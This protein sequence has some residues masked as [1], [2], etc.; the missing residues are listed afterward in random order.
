MEIL[1]KL[2]GKIDGKEILKIQF[3]NNNNYSVEF[4]N[5]GGYFHSICIPYQND[6][7]KTE[8]VL[9]GYHDFKSYQSD[10]ACLNALIGRVGGRIRN[11]E[12]FLNN[13]KFHLDLN[14]NSH[15][16]HGGKDGFNSQVW[17]ISDLIEEEQEM[18]C[19]LTYFSK[20]LEGGYPGNLNCETIYSLNNTNELTMEFFAQRDQDTIVNLTNHNYW[21]FHGH[22]VHYQ[23]VQRHSVRISSDLI[24]EVDADYVP[25]GNMLKIDNT[26][27]DFRNFREIDE[28]ILENSGIDTCYEINKTK[29]FKQVAKV[30]SDITKMGMVVST[31][32]PGLVFYTGNMMEN[33]YPGKYNKKYG[34]QYGLCM[35]A[36]IFPDAIN[37]SNFISPILLSN[38]T[39]S[40][41]T[42]MK[43]KNDF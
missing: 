17:E 15:H 26:K 30:Y 18:K 13:K 8:D 5:F 11:G 16:I 3:I 2:V 19:K 24:T 14:N 31:D 22:D 10:R 40:S 6:N 25:T 36:Q 32:Q 1:K 12:F 42:V 39:Y 27:Y 28:S 23:N 9:L 38:E 34:Y 4:Y 41:K 21:N 33:E 43:L 37:H 20:N 7:S 35:E 29:K